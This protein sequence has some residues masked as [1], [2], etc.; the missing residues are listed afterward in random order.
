MA[1]VD[2]ICGRCEDV[3]E[4][5]YIVLNNIHYCDGCSHFVTYDSEE[6]EEE[7]AFIEEFRSMQNFPPNWYDM[8]ADEKMNWF[9]ANREEPKTETEP[10]ISYLPENWATFT[11]DQRI[12]WMKG[13]ETIED[14]WK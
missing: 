13:V 5:D 14:L 10:V 2:L 8:T 3:I 1:N 6:D 7:E 12:C 11:L 9:L 4:E